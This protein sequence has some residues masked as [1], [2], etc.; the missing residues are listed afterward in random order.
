MSVHSECLF[1]NPGT[2]EHMLN[3]P[4][5]TTTMLYLLLTPYTFNQ[6][7][8]LMMTFLQGNY[9]QYELTTI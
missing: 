3:D 8:G 9:I 2:L 5:T 4:N 7:N 1:L 6:G